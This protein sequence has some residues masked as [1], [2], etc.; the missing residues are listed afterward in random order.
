[1]LL[2]I[3][4]P[5]ALVIATPVAVVSGLTAASRRG[6]LIKGG[7]HLED[8]GRVRGVVFDKT[9]TLSTGCP[10][11]TDVLPAGGSA[12]DTLALAAAVEARSAHPIAEAVL[13]RARA[14][15]LAPEPATEMGEI[16]GRGASGRV[17]GRVVLVGSHR[18]FDERGMCDHRLDA[19]LVRLESEGKS[20]LLVG[21]G[22]G[23]VGALA[24][25]DGLRPEAAGAIADL[26][27]A[28][29]PVAVLSGDNTRTVRA[30]AERLGIEEA[31]AELLPEGKVEQL[32]RLQS[33][34]G[35]VAMV[36][37]GINDAPALATA[38]V[39][40]AMGQRGTDAALETADVALMSEDLRL[41][42]F[43]LRLGVAT[44]RTIR[45]NI[46]L[47][48][49]VKALVLGLGLAGY[50]SLWAAVGADMGASLLV[51]ANGLR[52]LRPREA[53]PA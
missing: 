34:W 47:A 52:L 45:A 44:R 50:G 48:L 46:V 53:P 42:P 24:V 37:D 18:L 49:A 26:R 36:G 31:H 38:T 33:A 10:E 51:I 12:R 1:V 15:G 25:A 2:V 4:C 13:A 3:A 6:V 29:V 41:V 21:D 35:P 32:A 39:G 16:P 7:V 43:A 9:G 5:C 19:D 30:L 27:A 22:A 40:V 11:V 8:L 23:V 14:E 17:G 20:A 28:G